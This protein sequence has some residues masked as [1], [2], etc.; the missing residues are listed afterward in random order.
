VLAEGDAFAADGR[1]LSCANIELSD[2]S[3]TREPVLKQST[4][5]PASVALAD[6]LNELYEGTAIA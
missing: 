3:L 2:A 4:P 5:L 6:R 1:R